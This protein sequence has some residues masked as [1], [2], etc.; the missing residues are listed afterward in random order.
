M[1][2]RHWIEY[3]ADW[4]ASPMAYW[5]HVES[6]GAQWRDAP[7]YVPPAPSAARN[8]GFPCLIVEWGD[9][10]LEFSSPE[11]LTEFIQVLGLSP[12]PTSRRLS[13]HRRHGPNSHWL[14]RL[15]AKLKHPK[16]RTKLVEYLRTITWPGTG[17]D[18]RSA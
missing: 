14:S 3:I 7:G 18:P 16:A 13:A 11:Q 1:A 12:L 9:Q 10:K 5:I 8:L 4:R 15:P 6:E 17:G 2:G